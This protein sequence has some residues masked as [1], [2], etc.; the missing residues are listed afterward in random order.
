MRKI[1]IVIK[2]TDLKKIY[3][4]GIV[5]VHA[6]D[7]VN[8][9]IKKGEFVSILG[10]SGS[11]KSTFLNMIG[12]LDNPTSGKVILGGKDVSLMSKNQLA[13]QRQK[14]GFCFQYFNLIPRLTALENLELAM[15]IQKIKKNERREKA[16]EILDVLG[17]K[18][19]AN[20]RPD[21]LSGG[22][23]QR[24]AIARAVSQ[25]P[26]F[27]LMDEPTGN[28]DMKTRN[29]IM[30]WI[31]KL[32]KQQNLTVIV[33]TH[34]T[35]IAKVTDRQIYLIDGKVSTKPSDDAYEVPK[36]NEEAEERV[37]R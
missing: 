14:I 6:L 8:I 2:T 32:N 34:D 22:E 36:F 3:N 20:H 28:V 19:R 15:I 21:E 25:D 30:Y 13:E 9:E 37:V 31:Q 10:P 11:G 5:P 16:L 4:K 7:G 29:N 1:S 18:P 12:A 33:V 35:A 27:L 24:V 23:Q 17:L 26:M